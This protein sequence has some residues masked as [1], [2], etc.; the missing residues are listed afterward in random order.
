MALPDF[1][2]ELTAYA[3]GHRP[4]GIDEAGRGPWA[5][6]V[7][8][9]AVILDPDNIPE[10]LQDSKKL[11]AARRE[12]LFEPIRHSA[13]VGVGIV[14][15]A[16]IDR[17]NILQGTFLAMARA[18]AALPN[19]PSIALVDGNRAPPL[20]VR[21]QTIIGGDGRCLSIAAASI[22]AKVTRDRILQEL[23]S[24]Y[25]GYGFAR[26]KGYGTAAHL[27]A[28]QRLGPCA[29]HRFSF[30]PVAALTKVTDYD[31]RRVR[32]DS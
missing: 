22:I 16:E 25:P 31:S 28:L 11:T 3:G 14:E 13:Q 12:A 30:S 5:G 9:A 18:L 4:C 19:P 29:A 8:A 20:S 6:P 7:V 21:V 17:L 27:M 2:S 32:K 1:A 10:G 23:D 24:R 15:P 26:H